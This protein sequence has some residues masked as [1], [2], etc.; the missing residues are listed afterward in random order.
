M[1]TSVTSEHST[2]KAIAAT[3]TIRADRS[4]GL[5]EPQ[6]RAAFGDNYD[7]CAISTL[8]APGGRGTELHVTSHDVGQKKLKAHLRAYRALLETGEIPTGARNR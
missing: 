5:N 3:I 7:R 6:L 1:T 8:N 4:A 2:K